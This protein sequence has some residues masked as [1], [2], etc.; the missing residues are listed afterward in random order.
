[1]KL[2]VPKSREVFKSYLR[3]AGYKEKTIVT[4]MSYIK[5]FFSYIID[6]TDIND[7][8]E[9]KEEVITSFLSHLEKQKSHRTDKAYSKRYKINLFSCINLFFKALYIKE[10]LLF[11]P[12]RNIEY[13]PSGTIESKAIFTESEISMFLDSIQENSYLARRDRT[14]FELMYSSGLRPGEVVSV[15]LSDINFK[16]SLLLIKQ[17]KFGKDRIV[18]ISKTAMIYLKKF[19]NKTSADNY[20]FR[21]TQRHGKLEVTSLNRRFKKYLKNIGLDDKGLTSHSIRHSTATHLLNRGADLDYVQS[22]LG[23]E[24]AETTVVYTHLL[25]DKLKRTYKSYHPREN[26]YFEEV[27]SKYLK[28]ISK[29]E[30]SINGLKRNKYK[31]DG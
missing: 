24:S 11:N 4:K 1:M 23:H 5:V 12:S 29:L 8:R 2:T 26:E 21:S 14:I 18:P 10:K 3:D 22:L 31:L 30:D 9:I 13:E 6:H 17:G 20:I 7:L 25:G 16:E 27:D 15:K 19:T 28:E